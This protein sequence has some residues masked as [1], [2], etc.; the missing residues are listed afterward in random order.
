[1]ARLPDS[2][3]ATMSPRT[4]AESQ[5]GAGWSPTRPAGTRARRPWNN[6]GQRLRARS[7]PSPMDDAAA[8]TDR[9]G[10]QFVDRLLM[11][12]DGVFGH[13]PHAACPR[14]DAR[15]NIVAGGLDALLTAMWR[16]LF[17]VWRG[18]PD[19]RRVLD[20]PSPA[21]SQQRVGPRRRVASIL[22]LM[23]LFLIALVPGDRHADSRRARARADRCARLPD[24]GLA[25]DQA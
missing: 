12:S 9:A 19:H 13:R 21:S 20:R 11:L 4:G 3:R 16:P 10:P 24:D 6:E 17:A 2:G 1:M 25:A 7:R 5:H 8:R 15:R 14:A 22:S 23:L 18:L